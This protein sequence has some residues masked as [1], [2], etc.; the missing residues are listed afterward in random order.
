MNQNGY[1]ETA[2]LFRGKKRQHMFLPMRFIM[3]AESS[4]ACVVMKPRMDRPYS[5]WKSTW[6]GSTNQHR[7]T[8][9]IFL[10]LERN[11]QK[12]SVN[13]SIVMISRVVMSGRSV[14]TDRVP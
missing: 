10:T 11:S 13:S 6:T 14:I 3:E 8:A 12:P 9:W 4:R 2:A 7:F 1:G 5:V